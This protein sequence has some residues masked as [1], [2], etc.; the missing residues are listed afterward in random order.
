V[1]TKEDV[2]DILLPESR[3]TGDCNETLCDIEVDSA[4]FCCRT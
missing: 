4:T 2:D 3:F 1:F